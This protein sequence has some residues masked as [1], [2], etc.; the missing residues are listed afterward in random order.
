M[1][2]IQ[3]IKNTFKV[4]FILKNWPIYFLSY[5]KIYKKTPIRLKFRNK[6]KLNVWY[7]NHINEIYLYEIYNPPNFEIKDG[8]VI[9]DI[10]ANVGSYPVF[11]L[12]KAKNLNIFCF[13]PDLR[14]FNLLKKNIDENRGRGEVKI[15][16][17]GVSG[18]TG[19]KTLYLDENNPAGQS[20]FIKTSKSVVVKCISLEDIFKKNKIDKCDI[21]KIDC[22]GAEYGI[23]YSAPKNLFKKIE[24]ITMEFHKM[25]NNRRNFNGLKKLLEKNGFEVKLVFIRKDDLFSRVGVLYAR[26]RT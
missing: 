15:F 5:F 18:K 21:L 4:I 14:N 10:G 6:A 1:L 3:K 13:E 11:A 2:N 22:E 24:K 23:L 16:N 12:T 25:D 9:I 8:D 17:L 19:N 7:T 26:R 20:F